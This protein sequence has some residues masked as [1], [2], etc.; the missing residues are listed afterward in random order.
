MRTVDDI[1]RR[2]KNLKRDELS[3]LIRKLDA[4]LSFIVNGRGEA[5]KSLQV[6]KPPRPRGARSSGAKE[7]SK[8]SSESLLA[9]SGIARSGVSDVSSNKGKYLAEAYMLRRYG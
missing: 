1:L 5:S 6:H 3:R 9:L 8:T 4:H 2:A 7:R